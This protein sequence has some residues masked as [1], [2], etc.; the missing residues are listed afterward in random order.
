MS[1]SFISSITP[2]TAGEIACFFIFRERH[3]L[4]D[5]DQIPQLH[6]VEEIGL[7]AVR[8]QY[9][10][11]RNATHYYAAEVAA[12]TIPPAGMTFHKLRGTL[13]QLPEFQFWMAGRA[14]QVLEWDKNH[15][16][17]GRCGA[18]MKDVGY[19][20]AKKC[21]DC[22]LFNYPRISPAMIVQVTKD[23]ANG[24]EILLARSHRHPPNLFSVLAGF[25][26]PGE[27]L[28]ECV[29]REIR[30]EVGFS[31]KNIRYFGSQPWPFPNSLMVAF[32]AEHDKGEIE[33]NTDEMA[34]A[35]WFTADNFPIIPPL[36]TISR[37]L[38]DDFV[39]NE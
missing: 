33:L 37:Q 31:V 9:L 20:R 34:A 26:E 21:P 1:N 18:I 14:V 22:G 2:P 7:T 28:E 15:Q 35:D 36:P 11:H 5:R 19:E 8:Q 17:C 27:T 16:F 23:G 24:R 39:E 25:V 29:A 32:T 38:I 4:L 12:D 13:T 10:G 30:E 3:I 6:M